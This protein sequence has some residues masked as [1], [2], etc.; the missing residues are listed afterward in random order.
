[1]IRGL[2]IQDELL[3]DDNQIR[4]NTFA[5]FNRGPISLTIDDMNDFQISATLYFYESEADYARGNPHL[6]S[7]LG[8]AHVP[9]SMMS[10][11]NPYDL[12]YISFDQGGYFQTEIVYN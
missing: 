1:M 2:L 9:V 12:L 3:C 7:S 6:C 11:Q 10:E 8:S 5:C 4:H